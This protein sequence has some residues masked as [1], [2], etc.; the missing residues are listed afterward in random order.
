MASLRRTRPENLR[1]IT[2]QVAIVR[3]GPIQGGAVN[4]YIAR[5]QRMRVDPDVR[6]ALRRIRRWSPCWRRRWAPSSSRT[7]CWRWRSPS[8]GSAVGEA[9]GLRRAM[10]RKRSEAAIEAYHG[11]FV[12]GA[13]R[14]HGVDCRDRRAGV[15]DGQGVLRLRLPQGARSGVRPARLPVDVAARAL[16]RRSSSARCSTSSRWAS[17]R[18]TRSCTRPSAGA[19]R[20]SRRMSTRAG[21]SASWNGLP[22]TAGCG[23]AWPTSG[24][25]AS[26]M[27][28]SS[29][30]RA[31][32]GGR[33]RSLSDLASRAGCGAA[34]LELLALVG[35]VRRAGG[36]GR[37][38]GGCDRGRRGGWRSGSWG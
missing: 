19:S 28:P 22:P 7:R 32:S 12:A 31:G 27:W 8:P 34:A 16:L 33:F 6:G 11:R 18:R 30:P 37:G 4:P 20:S 15:R 1:D 9:E 14:K 2:I 10:S 26:R 25:S 38:G 17:I 5:R 29:S 21:W 24:A 3:P 35:R 36:A 23:S 13:Q